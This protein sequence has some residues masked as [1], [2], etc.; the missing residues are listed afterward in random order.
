MTK[1]TVCLRI[2]HHAVLFAL[3]ARQAVELCGEKGKES[4]L[5]GMTVY[6]KER[7]RRMACNAPSFSGASA[8][9]RKVC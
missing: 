2:E 9:T 4:I 1:K 3:L 7:G 5:R 8:T 6:G